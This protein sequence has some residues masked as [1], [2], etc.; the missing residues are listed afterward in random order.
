MNSLQTG[1]HEPEIQKKGGALTDFLVREL[2]VHGEMRG[3]SHKLPI[4]SGCLGSGCIGKQIR[5][6]RD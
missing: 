3:R 1:R 5:Q 6:M 2:G 4:R